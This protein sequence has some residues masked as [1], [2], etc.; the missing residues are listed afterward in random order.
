MGQA[1]LTAEKFKKAF[2]L[3]EKCHRVYNSQT[4]LTDQALKAAGARKFE[5]KYFKIIILILLY[6]STEEDITKFMH[7]YRDVFPEAS[8]TPKLHILEDHMVN[9]LW[10]W[11]VGCGLLGKQGAES[12]HTGY[13]HLNR[14]YAN[15]NSSEDRLLQ[16]TREHHRRTCPRLQATSQATIAEE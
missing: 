14:V 13:N 4:Y 15:I 2:I 16:V 7:Y 8:I 3:F 11:R 12:I 9:F 5:Y 6:L 1:V 10:N